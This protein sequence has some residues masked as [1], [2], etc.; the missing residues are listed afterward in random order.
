MT[1]R[2][3]KD[4][5]AVL[6]FEWDWTAWLAS[7]E[8]ISTVTITPATGITVDSHTNTNTTV[9]AWLSGGTAGVGYAV[10]CHITTSQARTDDR[11]IYVICQDR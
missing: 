8:T 1:D 5:N 7:A 4:P 9:T 11:T 3:V 2:F 6:D 10:L